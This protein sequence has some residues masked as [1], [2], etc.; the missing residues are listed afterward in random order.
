MENQNIIEE[1]PKESEQAY[2][3]KIDKNIEINDA[4]RS[5][6]EGSSFGK[7]SSAEDLVKAYNNLQAEFTRKCQKLSELQ[8]EYAEKE[9]KETSAKDETKF[10]T[11]VYE[12][13]NWRTQVAEFLMQNE[14][15]K[16]YSKEISY[17]ILRDKNLQ[18]QPNMLEIAWGR[19]LSKNFKTPQQ[20]A[21]EE[22]FV[23]D[24]VL[25][26]E[27]VKKQVLGSYINNLQKAPPVIGSGIVGGNSLLSKNNKPKNLSDAKFIAEKLLKIN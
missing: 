12:N 16:G 24:F 25:S 5:Q 1:Q 7:F 21:Q 22:D 15:A 10:N 9:L 3:E 13:E 26:N 23:K 17:E 8:K 14:K 18:N 20:L 11:P 27:N 6:N 4:S 2:D 19:V